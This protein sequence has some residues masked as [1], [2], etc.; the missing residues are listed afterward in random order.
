MH[1][2]P[3]SRRLIFA[4]ALPGAAWPSGILRGGQLMEIVGVARNDVECCAIA[5][6][7]LTQLR[8]ETVILTKSALLRSNRDS[9]YRLR[10]LGHR[11]IADFVDLKINDEVASSV[12]F[13]VASSVS[14]ERFF[15]E[16]F[17]Q[18]PTLHVTHHIDLR[19]P[20]IATPEDRARFG[21]FGFLRNCLHANEIADLICI[22]DA[23]SP[24]DTGWM[25]RLSESNAHYAIRGME[26][27]GVFKPFLKGFIAAHCGA[28]IIVASH[29]EE[30]QH[31]LGT[32]Y[33]FFIGDTSVASI[34]EHIGR[35]AAEYSTSRWKSAVEIMKV[36]AAKSSRHRVEQEL[37]ALF[38]AIW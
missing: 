35:F 36:V 4:Y 13:L 26:E 12:D 21:Y 1:Q 32:D 19:M 29:D 33:P 30:G 5:L 6:P 2:R 23:S 38:N 28:P 15:R 3:R 7:D 20:L 27:P 31:Y 8:G 16:R 10:A 18:I 22:V 9:I 11:L 34:R 24:A 25:S 17:F 14:Q 37:H